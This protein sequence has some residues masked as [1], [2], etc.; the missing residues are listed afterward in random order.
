MTPSTGERTAM[1]CRAS[2]MQS[3][4]ARGAD[5]SSAPPAD[6]ARSNAAQESNTI[7]RVRKVGPGSRTGVE[8]I[9]LARGVRG[10]AMLWNQP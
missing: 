8:F 10:A 4:S 7:R 6:A 2:I 9:G 5:A 3:Y 1:L